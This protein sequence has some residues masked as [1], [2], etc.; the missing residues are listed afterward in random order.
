VDEE[1]MKQ[2]STSNLNTQRYVWGNGHKEYDW[3]TASS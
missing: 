2:I 1:M 3:R